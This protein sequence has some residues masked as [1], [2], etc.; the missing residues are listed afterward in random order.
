MGTVIMSGTSPDDVVA[1]VKIA[2]ETKR[3]KIIPDYNVEDVSEHIV[4]IIQSY[5]H[6]VD[7]FV[8]RKMI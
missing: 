5:T 1:S 7:R 8:W 4:K 6:Y 3:A 2:V